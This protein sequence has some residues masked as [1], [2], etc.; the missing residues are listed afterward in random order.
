MKRFL[1]SMAVALSLVLGIQAQQFAAAPDVS[2]VR[3]EPAYIVC[4][5]GFVQSE[6][7]L[8]SG[9]VRLALNDLRVDIPGWRWVIVPSSQWKQTALSFG[10][11]PTVPA[12]SSLSIGTTYVLADLVL[13]NQRVDENLLSYSSRTGASR[14]RWV[15]AHESG[16]IVCRTSDDRKAEAAAGRIEGGKRDVCR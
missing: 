7:Q 2:P 15:L 5:T 13:P 6:C 8:A 10:V 12:F 16:H 4:G 3:V 11:K 14:L 9:F 1:F